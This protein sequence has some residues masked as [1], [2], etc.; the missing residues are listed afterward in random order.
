MI[1]SG[2]D[3]ISKG[4]LPGDESKTSIVFNLDHEPGTLYKAL[5]VFALAEIDLTKIESRPIAGKPWQYMFYIDFAENENSRVGKQ[6]LNKLSKFTPFLKV[7][8]SYPRHRIK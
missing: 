6:A 5:S 7:L 8:G 1:L 4:V 3:S 2:T